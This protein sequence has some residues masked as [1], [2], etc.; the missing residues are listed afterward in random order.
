ME[1]DADNDGTTGLVAELLS[2]VILLIFGF[3]IGYIPLPKLVTDPI[4]T[5]V[6]GFYPLSKPYY[7][8]KS[9]T[10]NF[11]SSSIHHELDTVYKYERSM[12]HCMYTV[13]NN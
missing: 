3:R 13:G 10:L 12:S 4:R 7:N 1:A 2:V 11:P 8:S 6:F 5:W 9:E